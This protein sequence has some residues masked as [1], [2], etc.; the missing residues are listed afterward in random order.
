MDINK[1]K[2]DKNFKLIEASAGTG[3]SFTLSHLLIR[4][5]IENRLKPEDILLLSFTK[6]TCYELKI[7]IIERIE[8]L[9]SYIITKKTDQVDK[10]LID[11][12]H[13]FNKNGEKDYLILS[14]INDFYNNIN[15]INIT[16]FHGL[17]NKISEEYSIEI[18]SSQGIKIDN[19]LDELY[20]NI[21]N[22][23][24][25]EEYCNLETNIIYCID[26]KKINTKYSNKNITKINKIFLF[27]LLKDIDQENINK[28]KYNSEYDNILISDF[29]KE[30]L[31]KNWKEFCILWKN[32]GEKLFNL[33]ITMGE[34]IKEKG[35][36]SKNYSAKPKNKF[37]QI[38]DWIDNINRKIEIGEA[39]NIIQEITKEDL[40]SKY[41]YSKSIDKEIRKFNIE[42]DIS[43]F[44]DLQDKIYRIKDGFFNEFIR[45][46]IY[47][48]YLR[49]EKLKEK[50]SINNFN[51]LIKK[52][53]SSIN[54]NRNNNKSI[55]ALKERYKFILI[56]EFQDTDKIQWNI[57]QTLFKDK[58]HFLLCVGDPKQAIYK[59]RGGDIDTYLSAKK[60]AYEIFNLINNYRSSNGLLEILNTLYK[61]GMKESD[62]QYTKLN[63]MLLK[64]SN[65][66]SY[67]K[68]EFQIIEF[69]AKENN[70]EEYVI[71]Y[72]LNL[73][74]R[75]D[76]L[77]LNKIAIL[78]FNNFQCEIYKEMLSKYNLPVNV[79]NKKNIFDTDSAEFIKI[80][81]SCLIK[82]TSLKRVILLATSKFFYSYKLDLEDIENNI[83]I[84]DL[85]NKCK[86]WSRELKKNGFLNIV[87]EL[88]DLLKS[89]SINHSEIYSNLFQISELIE[90]KLVSEKH[91]INKVFFWYL[92]A[93][94]PETRKEN[95]EEYFIKDY[96]SSVGINIS[97]IHSSK[98]LEYDIVLCPYLW[99]KVTNNKR[100]RGPIYKNNLDELIYINIE[101]NCSKVKKFKDIEIKDAI[102]EYERLIYVALT[103]A[104]Y[105]LIIFNNS[106]DFE[107][108]L[109]QNLLVNLRDYERFNLKEL[110]TLKDY[111]IEEIKNRFNNNYLKNNFWDN[112][113]NKIN[114]LKGSMNNRITFR[115]SYSGWINKIDSQVNYLSDDKDYEDNLS[116]ISSEK[117]VDDIIRL[118]KY[119][120]DPNP[121]SNFPK[122]KNAGTCIHKILERYNF[123][124]K[125]E[126]VL[127]FIIQEELNNHYI[128]IK[129]TDLLVEG[130]NRVLN[131]SLGNKLKNKRLIDISGSNTLKEVKYDL[132]IKCKTK[133][134]SSEDIAKSFL[135]DENHYFGKSYAAKVEELKFF[136]RGFHTG[137]IDCIIPIGEN[138]ESSK[139]WI[140]DWKSNYIYNQLENT[141]L[142]KNYIHQNIKDEMIRHHYPL[143]SH[144]YLL[145]LH[146]LLKWRLKDYDPYI[147]LGGYVYIFIRGLPEININQKSRIK[148]DFPGLFIGE[149]PINRINYLDN[150]FKNGN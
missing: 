104:K 107:N 98:G 91:N 30:Y 135:L 147:N 48:A 142:P 144:L 2:I 83:F 3:K 55:F 86:V 37:R 131:T 102:N 67:P 149:A 57:I 46:F 36:I 128:D 136:S 20:E 132:A 146:R 92:N 106:D 88:L 127:K 112:K 105:K 114:I 87:N 140:I 101:Q 76:Y 15:R 52:V 148:D 116:I 7:K 32:Q 17:C 63:A 137:F 1:I 21:I 47:K 61:Q 119:L 56:D 34:I 129:F 82:P 126:K 40:L 43:K 94:D 5:I 6:N 134:I 84:Q 133:I 111:Q 143:Q 62:I 80:F 60:E 19:N 64:N 79:I 122:G 73:I 59:F 90:K 72:L 71:S 24:W 77:D 113:I 10:T 45:I 138:P 9:Q 118:N 41:F 53:D 44:L 69:S 121:L 58:K 97:T 100:S 117:K 130:I 39:N 103:R 33:L 70:L 65:E 51:D 31:F 150:L 22:E 25:I 16:T 38:N 35:Y 4:G 85:L 75:N 42:F 109:N 12:Y 96:S 145:A 141:C 125:S 27:N 99:G 26:N 124:S 49:L 93:M 89:K 115:S 120:F 139:W 78:T 110:N 23:L 28:L 68:S 18:S 29:L 66:Y 81:L 54:F 11:W 13:N 74:I 8:K 95:G 108:I 14:I 123:E 50:K